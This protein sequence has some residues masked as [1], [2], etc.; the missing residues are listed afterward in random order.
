L[1]VWIDL[2]TPPQVLFFRPIVA[3]LERRGHSVAITAR[4]FSETVLLLKQFGLEAA[5]IGW[6]GGKTLVGK[7]FAILRR[8]GG[9]LAYA[10]AKGFAVAVSHNSYAQ[11]LAASV[12][13][14]P[15]V[16]LMDYEHQPAN[17]VA[18]RLARRVIVPEVFPADA[19]RRYGVSESKAQRYRG[20]KE[21]VYLADFTPDP[22]LLPGLGI[23]SA[24]IVVTVR[25]PATMATYHRFENPLFDKVVRYLLGK[26]GVCV[27]FLPR[28]PEQGRR[29]VDEGFPNLV[30]PRA[31]LDG[32]NLI[33]HSDLVIRGGGTMNREAAVLG[34]PV[35]TVYKGRL[36]AVDRYLL[37]CGRMSLIAC[38]R[39]ISHIVLRKKDG[40]PQAFG[41]PGLLAEVVEMILTTTEST[42]SKRTHHASTV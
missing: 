16:T 19:L 42:L 21:E 12:L 14:L 5:V 6:H 28:V 2:A 30:V 33:Y 39:D 17:H 36:G 27:V 29:L 20:I 8:T 13:R 40:S 26:P 9:L 31:P 23:P 32:P 10:R 34:T 35:Y 18:F 15:L 1:V 7:A 37:D 41:R 22:V 11:A 4:D 38:E 3:E 25:P 24:A